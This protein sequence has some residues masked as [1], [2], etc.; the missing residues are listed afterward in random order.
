MIHTGAFYETR[1]PG[2]IDLAASRLHRPYPPGPITPAQG[3][4][5]PALPATGLPVSHPI[6]REH[7]TSR[8]VPKN[9]DQ[10][11]QADPTGVDETDR[12][13][14]RTLHSFLLAF[15]LADPPPPPSTR[16]FTLASHG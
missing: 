11:Q 9:Q 1:T 6:R 3:T 16:T 4:A 2:D 14:G 5:T 8:Q 15:A 7:P 13:P 10:P 12:A